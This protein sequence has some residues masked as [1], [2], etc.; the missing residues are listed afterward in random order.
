MTSPKAALGY[1]PAALPRETRRHYISASDADIRDMLASL[2]LK[3]LDDLYR[4]IP[5]AL[6]FKNFS[7][8]EELTYDETRAH[9]EKLSGK[10]RLYPTSFLCDGLPSWKVMDIVPRVCA[11][12]EL[13]TAYT[14]YQPERSQGTLMTHWL[15]QC[16]IA[17]LSG[18]EAVNASMYDRATTLYEALMTAVRLSHSNRP[19]CIL[20]EGLYPGDIQVVETMASH[21]GLEIVRAP[22]VRGRSD[23]AVLTQLLAEYPG[24]V[25]VAFAQTTHFGC[26]EDVD[27][28]T[29]TI[30]RSPALAIA[31]VDP[32]LLGPGG[33]KAPANFGERGADMFVA[34]GQHLALA[35]N[36]GG[37]GLGIFGIRFNKDVKTH[38]RSS[39]GRFVGNARDIFGRE[40]KVLVLS[41]REQ[42]IRREKATSNICTNQAFVAT[43]AGAALLQRG[44]EGLRQSIEIAKGCAQLAA[45]A[46]TAFEGVDLYAGDAPFLNEFTLKIGG[47]LTA[48][49][50]AARKAG[51]ELGVD[52]SA[53]AADA[54]S[55]LHLGFSDRHTAGDVETLRAFFSR[56]FKVKAEK[57]KT[58][59]ILP[60][61]ALLRRAAP[62]IPR[63]ELTE[64]ENYYQ[65]LAGQN[66]SPDFSIY[67]LGSCTM[68]YNPYLNDHAAALPGFTGIHPAAA[69]EDAQG[70]LELL[71]QTQEDFKAILGLPGVTVQPVAGAQGELVGLKLFQAWHADRGQG[72][73]DIVIIPRSAHGTNPATATVAGYQTRDRGGEVSGIVL[74]E[75][76]ASGLI[77][78]AAMLELIARHADR[79]VGVM[80]TNPNTSGIFETRFKEISDAVHRA[81]GLV[82]M[83]GANMNAIAGWLDLGALGV[84]A[85][86]NNTH[87]TWSIPHGGG[88]PGD[89]VVGVSEKLIPYLPGP[90]IVRDTS[91]MYRM[92]RAEKSIGSIHR[93]HGNF[94]HKVRLYTYLRRLGREGIRRMSAVAVLSSRYLVQRLSKTLPILPLGTHETPRMHEFILTL[95]KSAFARAEA[96][97]LQKSEVIPRIGKLF[98]DFGFHAPTV[99]FPEVYGLMVEPTESYSKAELDRFADAVLEIY[100]LVEEHPEVLLTVPHFTPIDRVDDVAANRQPELS[101]KLQGL[102]EILKNRIEPQTLGRMSLS[103]IR[104]AILDAH[105]RTAK[106]KK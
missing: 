53:R 66:V 106:A 17:A 52:V 41:T 39:P 3:E 15:Y 83:D 5:D 87:K 102:P 74:V 13:T 22:L 44:D 82:Y 57:P 70:C 6:K 93:H 42:H 23:A 104:Q 64:L 94:A 77:D 96:A 2:G 75:A 46:L 40:C 34:E 7:F 92:D 68:K 28:L 50:R 81:G 55:L 51:I 24:T 60:P 85:V 47:D 33:L 65:R 18:F 100:R 79:L 19:V 14:P 43:L 31:V 105:R 25:A 9:L 89:G 12:R 45:R 98:L 101:Q 32:L 27:L 10:N 62:G 91:G 30:Q 88:G 36:F 95:S 63:I 16:S 97:G 48:L 49:L 11:L 76:D 90:V 1:N 61:P 84:D 103:E 54:G 86:H 35:P 80:I 38:I 8:A 26:L 69:E 99:A 56:H 20:S 29:D 71:Y 78:H 59:P 21:T 67:P 73:R 37:P 58:S 4:H 72:H